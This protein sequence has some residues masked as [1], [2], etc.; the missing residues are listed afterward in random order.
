MYKIRYQM[1]KPVTVLGLLGSTLDRG[2]GPERW[3]AWRPTVDICRHEDLL[4]RRF[5]LLHE[6]AHEPLARTVTADIRAVSPE[7][8]VH[9]HVMEFG[10]AWDFERVY[11][12]LHD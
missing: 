1:L 8:A 5:D 9:T 12:A 10:D 6:P 3:N 11:G 7:T 2:L 4:V